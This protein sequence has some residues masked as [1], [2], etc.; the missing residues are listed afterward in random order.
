MHE[1]AVVKTKSAVRRNLKTGKLMYMERDICGTVTCAP[2]SLDQQTSCNF[3]VAILNSNF[4]T[5][6]NCMH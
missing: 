1:I 6:R 3:P 2:V 4:K 5:V